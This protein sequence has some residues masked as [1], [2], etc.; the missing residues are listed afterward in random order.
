MAFLCCHTFDSGC[1]PV[2]L[3]SQS[4][5]HRTGI[6]SIGDVS[7]PAKKAS[8][9]HGLDHELLAG[10]EVNQKYPA[11]HLRDNMQALYDPCGGILESEECIKAYLTASQ[12]GNLKTSILLETNHDASVHWKGY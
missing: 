5:F 4:L 2:V 3:C 6:L 1:A 12:V 7:E 9:E 10:H 8:E 11:Y